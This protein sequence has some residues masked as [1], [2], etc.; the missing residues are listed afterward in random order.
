MDGTDGGCKG[1][2]DHAAIVTPHKHQVAGALLF[3]PSSTSA[4]PPT[5]A[6][7]KAEA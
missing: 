6:G 1:V 2:T 7:Q 5:P 3:E 4:A